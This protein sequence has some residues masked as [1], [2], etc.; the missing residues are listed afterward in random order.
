MQEESDRPDNLR[1]KKATSVTAHY[2]G[3]FYILINQMA[4]MEFS[5]SPAVSSGKRD[6]TPVFEYTFRHLYDATVGLD[7]RNT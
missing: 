2:P 7:A 4:D 5:V 6:L 3:R 1:W